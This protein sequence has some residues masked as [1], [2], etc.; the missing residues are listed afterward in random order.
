MHCC[1]LFASPR[2]DVSNTMALL[3]LFRESWTAAGHTMELFPLYELSV[4]PCR[5]C[6]LCQ[7]DHTTPNCAIDDDMTPI[8][9]AV[10]RC[11]LLLLATPIY[12]WYCTAPMKAALDRM[13][14]A[15]NKFYGGEKGPAL[16]AG[17]RLAL[18]ST[19]GYRPERGADLLIDGLQRYCR[20]SQLH[21]AGEL[22]ARHLGYDVPF[23]TEE[24]AEQART[25]AQALM[26]NI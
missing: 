8:F 11:D 12:S 17:K 14:Y 15:M 19:C 10:L 4:A 24:I 22:V 13:V 20:H 6:R 25:F 21:Y 9:D 18:L 16:W 3:R 1:V 2:G 5:A 26:K 23:L 7:Q